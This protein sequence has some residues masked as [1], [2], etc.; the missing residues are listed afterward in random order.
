MLYFD[1]SPSKS[2]AQSS[3]VTWNNTGLEHGMSR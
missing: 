2:G 1:L 3:G